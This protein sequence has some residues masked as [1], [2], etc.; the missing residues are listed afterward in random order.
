MLVLAGSSDSQDNV[1]E[2][3]PPGMPGYHTER[4]KLRSTNPVRED[5]WYASGNARPFLPYKNMCP[6]PHVLF[7]TWQNC[8]ASWLSTQETVTPGQSIP[9]NL[10]RKGDY[11]F[12]IGL[13]FVQKKNNQAVG[14][15][16]HVPLIISALGRTEGWE[17]LLPKDGWRQH[18]FMKT[19]GFE[20][21]TFSKIKKIFL[22]FWLV[23]F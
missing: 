15:K 11:S 6:V 18:S 8:S 5:A 1:F 10:C 9:W 22:I 3:L 4:T 2:Q 20:K 17:M 16:H 23:F 7:L 12:Q 14:F 13:S 19:A 21:W